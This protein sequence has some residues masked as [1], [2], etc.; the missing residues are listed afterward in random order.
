MKQQVGYF[1]GMGESLV[2]VSDRQVFQP[3]DV[4]SLLHRNSHPVRISQK[5]QTGL[6]IGLF[7]IAGFLIGGVLGQ[8]LIRDVVSS[9][10]F[11]FL[12]V[13][14]GLLQSLSLSAFLSTTFSGGIVGLSLGVIVGLLSLIQVPE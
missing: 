9:V 13:M 11:G 7:A 2:R 12:T 6:K 10:E 3:V 1:Y 4:S 5:W 14:V 8:L